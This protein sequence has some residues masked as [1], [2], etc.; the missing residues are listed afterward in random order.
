MGGLK[1]RLPSRLQRLALIAAGLSAAWMIVIVLWG[2]VEFRLLGV[3]VRSHDWRDAAT[4]TLVSLL[5]LAWPK[6][7]AIGEWC[8]ARAAATIGWLATPENLLLIAILTA[9][10]F[11]RFWALT[12][13]LPHPAARPDEEAVGALA[14]SYLAG[15]FRP[16]DFTY[17]P[18]FVLLVAL[19]S[20]LSFWRL[21]ATLHYFGLPFEAG[22]PTVA[23][24]R[25]LARVLSA[26]AGVFSVWLL[27]RIALRLFG[28][29]T[30]FVASAFLPLAF[31]HVRDSHFGVT[32]IPMTCMVLAG[33]LGIVKMSHSRTRR[34]LVFAGICT[35]LAVATKYNAALLVVPACFGI[36]AGPGP[37]S[38]AHRVGRFAAFAA[39][40]IGTFFVVCPFALVDYPTF[41]KDLIDIGLHLRDGHGPNLGRGW[42][43]HLTI[44]LRYGLG[45][46]LLT[47]GI[48]GLALMVWR[49]GF[50]G[51]LVVLFP[52]AYYV[53][54]GSGRTVFA[55][56]AL[57]L[58]PFLCLSAGY[59]VATVADGLVNHRR[60]SSWRAAVAAVLAALVLIPSVQSIVA[61]SRLIA[62]EDSRAIAR[63]W[64][65]SRFAAGTTILQLG[66]T[67]G[68]VYIYYEPRYVLSE[69][70][71]AFRPTLVV[72]VSS[73]LASPHL[74]SIAPWV[75]REYELQFAEQV[76]SEDDGTNI[77]DRQDEF[78]VP[79]SGFHDIE[80]PGPNL[81]IYVR[82]DDVA[83]T[84]ARRPR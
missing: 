24:Q 25:T 12:F 73:P 49:E 20:W 38:M 74:D 15:T 14:A 65:E 55:R 44:T 4:L 40:V 82:R 57:P 83:G 21:P 7:A 79:L 62:R 26:T 63:R 31:L 16:D 37:S 6:R 77:Y 52:L 3:R 47:A 59:L 27:F 35:G 29:R 46:P 51:V 42:A 54:S 56:H 19:A 41:F 71:S 8:R 22:D 50:R 67:N 39:I 68:H 64:I 78:F 36:L 48:V 75:K 81:H 76:V 13:G 23:A 30:A 43:Y 32:D 33:F 53:V 34:D 1:S 5:A 10:A 70:P 84:A 58:V 28:A 72:L 69:V 60:A 18:L 17:P 80:R 9:A 61:F 11:V 2:G 66:Q 45:L